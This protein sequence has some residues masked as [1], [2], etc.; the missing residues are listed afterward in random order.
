MNKVQE[1]FI[2]YLFI[3]E[4]GK[5]RCMYTCPKKLS[6]ICQSQTEGNLLYDNKEE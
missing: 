4:C 5:Y 3:Q 1:Q 2:K 6:E